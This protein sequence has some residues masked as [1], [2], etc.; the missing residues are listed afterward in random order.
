MEYHHLN[1]RGILK[2]EL[3]PLFIQVRKKLVWIERMRLETLIPIHVTEIRNEIDLKMIMDSHMFLLYHR[4]TIENTI[5]R[6]INGVKK[7]A[8]SA[9]IEMQDL[10]KIDGNTE[11]ISQHELNRRIKKN[12]KGISLEDKITTEEN[13]LTK[14]DWNSIHKIKKPP[15]KLKAQ[16]YEINEMNM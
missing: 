1:V 5:F 3:E 11:L 14:N 12:I 6:E 13:T 16:E 2:K 15:D 9:R 7:Q 10:E 8:K 4:T